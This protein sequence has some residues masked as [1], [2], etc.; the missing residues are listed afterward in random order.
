MGLVKTERLTLGVSGVAIAPRRLHW[1]RHILNGRHRQLR[2]GLLSVDIGGNSGLHG[3]GR[4]G[5]GNLWADGRPRSR[6]LPRVD[7]GL[8]IYGVEAAFLLEANAVYAPS[9][10]IILRWN[11]PNL[12]ATT[13]AYGE[14]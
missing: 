14:S 9:L 3:R 10:D 11:A 1:R 12:S 2:V 13:V 7:R 6:L 4:G 5:R 8:L